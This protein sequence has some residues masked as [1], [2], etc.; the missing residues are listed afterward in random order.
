MN[1]D[2]LQ[3]LADRGRT[4]VRKHQP[5]NNSTGDWYKIT[6]ADGDRAELYIYGV[7]G[8]EWDDSDATSFTRALRDITAPAIDL[9][10]NSPGGLVF[11][12]VAIYSALLNHPSTVDV[13]V[14]GIAASAASFVAMSGD[15][16]AVEKPAKLMIHDASGLVIGNAADMLEMA[17]L[18]DGMSDTIAEIYAD[19]AGGEVSEWRDRMRAETWFSAEQAVAAGLAD[20]IANDTTPEPAPANSRGGRTIHAAAWNTLTPRGTGMN[21]EE[22]LAAMQ[23]IIDGADGRTMTDDEVKQY[24]ALEAKLAEERT[25]QVRQRQN[26]YKAPAPENAQVHAAVH[27]APAKEDDGLEKAFE[28]YLRTGQPTQDL[29]DLRVTNAQGTGAGADGGFTVPDGFRQKLVDVMK[30]YGGLAAA[31]ESF[32]TETGNPIDYPSLDDTGNEGTIT[33]ENT[34][35]TGGADLEFGTVKLGAYKY[36]SAGANNQPL[37]VSVELLQDSAF[38]IA[39][40]VAR[41]LGTRIARKQAKDWVTGAGTTLPFG[42]AHAGLTADH[43]LAAGNAITY[44]DLLDLETALDPAYEQT[45]AWAMNKSSWNAIRGVTDAQGRPLVW[46]SAQSGMGGAPSRMLLGYPVVIDQAFPNH[47]TLS[48][49]W[50]VLGD[51]PE[52]YVIRRVSNLA[53]VVNPYS[54]ANSG[55]VEYTAWERADGNI[56]NRPAYTLLAANAT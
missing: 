1:V 28:N 23:N 18:L 42:I 32:P 30:A 49:H 26:Q 36:T 54:S 52:A 24:E 29:A 4:L 27:A 14:D 12:G 7:I 15:T 55:Q 2:K 17:E 13:H 34:A 6:N 45:A 11:D 22:L 47:N 38:D 48:S 53:V 5:Q 3:Q 56:Q 19:R 21:I 50:A 8:D 43:T 46:E 20:R 41:K 35:I 9:H 33:A 44:Q 31:V 51:L 10:I 40:L 37:K 39:G 16:I 25:H